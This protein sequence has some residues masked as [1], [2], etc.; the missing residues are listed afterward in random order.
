ML[1]TQRRLDR[2]GAEFIFLEG[3]ERIFLALVARQ[4][5]FVADRGEIARAI[6]HAARAAPA[7]AV[8]LGEFGAE[9]D[10]LVEEGRAGHAIVIFSVGIIALGAAQPELAEAAV[11][12]E[13]RRVGKECVSTCRSRWSQYH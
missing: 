2:R 1:V 11:R 12:S 9:L 10:A 8:V 4:K 3:E 6:L 5:G 7:A 13:E